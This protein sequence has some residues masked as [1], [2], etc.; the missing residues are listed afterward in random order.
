MRAIQTLF[1]LLFT[2]SLTAAEKVP[3][4]SLLAKKVYFQYA[5]Y[6]IEPVKDP[7]TFAE[8]LISKEFK[9]L[10]L[11]PKAID[12]KITIEVKLENNALKKY[13]APDME[14]LRYFGK[15]VSKEQAN[16]LQKCNKAIILN[17]T[18]PTEKAVQAALVSSKL[19]YR[20]SALSK[21]IPWDEE[22]RLCFSPERFKT[23][24]IDSFTKSLIDIQDH[25]VIHSYKDG[26]FIR[27]ITLGMSKFGLP[28]IEVSD[29]LW[30]DNKGIG[31]LINVTA[32]LLLDYGKLDKAG[33]LVIDISKIKNPSVR[34]PHLA[35]L[36][37]NAKKSVS[38]QV[39]QGKKEQGDADNRILEIVFDKFPGKAKQEKMEAMLEQLWGSEDS[40]SYVKH[41]E[42][43]LAAS[44]KAKKQL[45][46]IRKK[47]LAGLAPGEY[48]MF[49]APF[50]T[51]D[52]GN[53]WMWVEVVKWDKADVVEGILKN[54]PY[55]I[56][57]LKAGANVKIKAAEVFD[58]IYRKADGSSEGNETGK[59]MQKFQK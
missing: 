51:P 36:K 16:K 56:P 42:A 14:S 17:F 4:G 11:S 28:E 25:I 15:G 19:L 20:L 55:H 33:E 50:K 53:E 26:D 32:Q 24:R 9:E 59:L 8:K 2:F 10:I 40:I 47:I 45:P 1:V 12:G 7:K 52:Q 5:V 22:T 49:K 13:T 18:A 54:Q 57:T 21:G 34:K 6:L 44:Q 35:S 46:A 48:Y 39:V 38:I 30:S 58:Y 43:I 31:N 3:A 41:N 37:K 23:K 29:F 27:A